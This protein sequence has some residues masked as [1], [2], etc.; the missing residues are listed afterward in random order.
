MTGAALLSLVVLIAESPVTAAPPRPERVLRFETAPIYYTSAE[1]DNALTQL[2]DEVDAGR[3]TLPHDP[4]LGPLP[5]VLAALDVPV[6]S[7]ALAFAKLSLQKDKIG[8]AS[9]RAVYFSDDAYVGYVPGGELEAAVTD[10]NLGLSFHT[11]TSLPPA[12]E[13]EA[14][15][16]LID[17]ETTS[18]LTCHAGSRTRGVPGLLV[19]SVFPGPRGFPVL[20][21]ADTRTH[22]G[23]P[24]SERFGGWY[25]TGSTGPG[26]HRGNFTLPSRGRPT[27]PIDNA[28]GRNVLRLAGRFDAAKYPSP[29][30]DV[31][32][33]MTLE[34]QVDAHN[35]MIRAGYAFRLDRQAGV[36]D[37]PGAPW[38][39]EAETLL[40]HLLFE[41]EW[42]LNHP[43]EGVGGF[44]QTFEARGPFERPR[45]VAAAVRPAEPAVPVSA[46]LHRAFRRLRPP[47]GAGAIPVVSAAE[48]GD[49]RRKPGVPA[50]R[51]RGPRGPAG[52]PAGRAAGVAAAWGDGG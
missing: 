26:S 12:A 6:E 30:S 2:A 31:V 20:P 3:R 43:V 10:P 45:P 19:R 13:R 22:H 7:Q 37:A 42:A 41:G 32:A 25:V 23:S 14:P 44:R 34:H 50:P 1:A 52:D 11:L 39:D 17:R 5:A 28:A 47:A 35:L 29:H 9:P 46:E 21:L 48:G 8:P 24:L 33:L 15:G 38:R 49:G 27:G 36:H 16:L 4:S 40:A 51:P 18:C